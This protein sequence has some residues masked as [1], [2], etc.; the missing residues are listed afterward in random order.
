M[1]V[2][3]DQAVVAPDWLVLVVLVQLVNIPAATAAQVADLTLVAAAAA[4][5]Q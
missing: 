3:V 2:L 5:V 1:V 4:L